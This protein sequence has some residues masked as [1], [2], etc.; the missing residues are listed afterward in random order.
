[1]STKMPN[2]MKAVTVALPLKSKVGLFLAK[3]NDYPIV[4]TFF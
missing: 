2:T 4:F 1:M 3:Y